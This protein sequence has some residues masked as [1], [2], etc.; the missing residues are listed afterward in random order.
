M[1]PGTNASG[2][3]GSKKAG[4]CSRKAVSGSPGTATD[5]GD[6]LEVCHLCNRPEFLNRRL[7]GYKFCNPCFN[8]VRSTR[9][10]EAQKG[11]TALED[12]DNKM[13]EKPEE[14]RLEMMTKKP[15]GSYHRITPR[16]SY[17][18]KSHKEQ[19]YVDNSVVQDDILLNRTRF[20][21]FHSWWDKWSEPRC[22]ILS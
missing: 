12:L 15:E 1:A 8:D 17:A 3:S 16:K 14:W 6:L 19:D 21:T 22:I 20:Q 7:M 9:R 4:S 11:N 2:H 5:T 18:Q 10:K 13:T